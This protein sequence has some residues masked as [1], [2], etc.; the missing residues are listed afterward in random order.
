MYDIHDIL[1]SY[2]KVAL[3]RFIE[4]VVVQVIER[5]YIGL[6]GPAIQITPEYVRELSDQ[7]LDEVAYETYETARSRNDTNSRL[8]RLEEAVRIAEEKF[9]RSDR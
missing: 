3:K 5:Y 4:N 6:G 9:Q 1:K 8:Q 7:D 2:Y